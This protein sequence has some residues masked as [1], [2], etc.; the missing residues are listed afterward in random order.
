MPTVMF[1]KP[2]HVG[3]VLQAPA[4]IVNGFLPGQAPDTVFIDRTTFV[5][6]QLSALFTEKAGGTIF[7]GLD[8]HLNCAARGQIHETEGGHE[9]DGGLRSDIQSKIMIARGILQLRREL[10][11]QG[12]A[13][14]NVIPTFFSYNPAS[15]CVYFGL[16]LHVH[17]PEVIRNGYSE[18]TLATLVS[19]GDIISTRELLNDKFV[20]SSLK[21]V[22]SPATA[23]FRNEYAQSLLANWKAIT[24]LYDQGNGGLYQYVYNKM[25][26]MYQKAG[27]IIR[28]G[29]AFEHQSISMQTLQQKAKF[30]LKNLVTRYSIAGT[31]IE[32]PYD[33]HQEEMAVIT[34]GGYAPFPDTDAF[35]VFSRDLNALV[36]N[37]K[38]TIDL[39]R[40]S[41]HQ[42]KLKNPLQEI[43]LDQESFIAAPVIISNKAIVKGLSEKDWDTLDEVDLDLVLSQ[44]NWDNP[45]VLEWQKPDIT[46]LV[47]RAVL[48]KHI[49]LEMSGVLRFVDGVYELFDRM[50]LL[51]KDKHFRHMMF[52]GSILVVNTIVD[53]ERYPRMIL[54]LVA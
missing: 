12:N 13:V 16:E 21:S 39:I 34:D 27:W 3:G 17:E 40:Q 23:D 2:P 9:S 31:E 46:D 44:I 29:D 32:W 18:E 24:A 26:S 15:G 1:S 54:K 35:A 51:L 41:R 25:A 38:L 28:E 4:G 5:V 48:N 8:S 30:L 45:A 42:K 37:T 22:I 49:T 33:H 6:R 50:R 53:R 47:L 36:T 52:T 14:C 10:R 11:E 7:Y 19:S 20:Q 43:P